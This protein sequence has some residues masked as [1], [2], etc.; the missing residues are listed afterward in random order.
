VGERIASC[1]VERNHYALMHFESRP[2]IEFMRGGSGWGWLEYRLN[3]WV[4]LFGKGLGVGSDWGK[5]F[6]PQGLKPRLFIGAILLWP[7]GQTYVC[8]RYF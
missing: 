2:A 8:C 6:L 3:L 7:K 5:L 4:C 1:L